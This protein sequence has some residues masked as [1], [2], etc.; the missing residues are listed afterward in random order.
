LVAEKQALH[1]AA[2]AYVCEQKVCALPTS[3]PAVLA[4]QL[5]KV[6]RLE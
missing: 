4:A 3:D 5:A 1:G 6:H 2:T